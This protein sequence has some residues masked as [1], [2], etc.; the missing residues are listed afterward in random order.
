LLALFPVLSAILAAFTHRTGGAD[1]VITLL[2]ALARG[3]AS[4]A[5][6]CFALP[7]L[8]TQVSI[9][10]AFLLSVA[11]ALLIQTVLWQRMPR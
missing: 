9:G 5:G 4:L 6:F 1:A 2:A 11:V 10:A 8:L 7:L 3:L